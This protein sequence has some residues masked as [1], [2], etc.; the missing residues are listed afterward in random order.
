MKKTISILSIIAI[1]LSVLALLW[2]VALLFG[3]WKQVCIFLYN[4]PE[5]VIAEGPILPIGN[6]VYIVGGIALVVVAYICSKS[7]KTIAGEI[8][9]IALLSI[10]LPVIAS[11][12]SIAQTKEIGSGLGTASALASLN[13]ATSISGF[14]RSFMNVAAALCYVACGISISEKMHLKKAALNSTQT[15]E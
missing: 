3:F 7:N 15:M 9:S 14:A 2:A 4:A 10:V 6:I 11:R 1:V 13:V 8:V 12:L 5:T